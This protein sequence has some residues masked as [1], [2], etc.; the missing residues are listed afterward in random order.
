MIM[1]QFL[2][3][4]L[5]PFLYIYHSYSKFFPLQYM[6]NSKPEC[7]KNAKLYTRAHYTVSNIV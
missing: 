1:L 4:V 2:K 3:L 7:K 6:F 5:I